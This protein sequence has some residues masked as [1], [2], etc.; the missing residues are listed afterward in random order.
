MHEPHI[1]CALSDC[2]HT[3]QS[4]LSTQTWCSSSYTLNSVYFFHSFTGNGSKRAEDSERNNWRCRPLV[5]VWLVPKQTL[6]WIIS[7][8]CYSVCGGT[9]TSTQCMQSWCSCMM[10][11][12]V[13]FISTQS[14]MHIHSKYTISWL[15]VLHQCILLQIHWLWPHFDRIPGSNRRTTQEAVY[16]NWC[17]L[18]ENAEDAYVIPLTL[19]DILDFITGSSRVPPMRFSPMPK[20][21]F[22]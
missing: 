16:Y 11:C 13:R 22:I 18:L 19:G 20:I 8:N 15:L 14:W 10:L 7:R 4:I 2:V 1:N 17:K 12:A 9:S 3:F 6:R 21:A 5:P